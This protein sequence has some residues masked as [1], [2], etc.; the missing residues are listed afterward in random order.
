MTPSNAQLLHSLG[1]EAPQRGSSVTRPAPQAA[2]AAAGGTVLQQS[3]TEV[4]WGKSA[5][6]SLSNKERCTD[7]H[8]GQVQHSRVAKKLPAS[9]A[10]FQHTILIFCSSWSPKPENCSRK[11]R[12]LSEP[13]VWP[14]RG[15]DGLWEEAFN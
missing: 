9:N 1:L 10:A 12:E 8:M 6:Q 15:H 3:F 13:S 2:H 5:T 7:I 4:L 14:S 11:S